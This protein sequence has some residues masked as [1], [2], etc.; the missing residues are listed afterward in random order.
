MRNSV[1]LDTTDTYRELNDLQETS[2]VDQQVT[3]SG[4]SNKQSPRVQVQVQEE[5]ED[6]FSEGP[7]YIWYTFGPV[8]KIAQRLFLK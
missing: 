4:T 2:P 1:F 7:F 8:L 6:A 3:H 5:S